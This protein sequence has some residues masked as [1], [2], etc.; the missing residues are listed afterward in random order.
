[1]PVKQY[2]WNISST[3][4]I[5]AVRPDNIEIVEN[6][7]QE[8]VFTGVVESKKLK[9]YFSEIYVKADISFV[10]LGKKEN[11]NKEGDKINIRIPRGKVIVMKRTE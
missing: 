2:L 3:D 1:M 4:V 8:N 10:V 6:S 11:G 9:P 7:G 5:V